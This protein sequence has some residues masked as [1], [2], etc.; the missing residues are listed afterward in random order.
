MRLQRRA[1]ALLARYAG[2]SSE[3]ELLEVATIA[4]PV[5]PLGADWLDR[6]R[7]QLG[8]SIDFTGTL[9]NSA[10]VLFEALTEDCMIESLWVSQPGAAL[11]ALIVAGVAL[12]MPSAPLATVATPSFRAAIVPTPLGSDG[13]IGKQRV[14]FG[15]FPP[16][17]AGGGLVIEDA[18]GISREFPVRGLIVQAGDSFMVQAFS[19]NT[20]LRVAVLYRV[21]ETSPEG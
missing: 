4:V 16:I 13:P 6:E 7:P 19:A 1:D 8:Y 20:R 12:L 9:G 10:S 21:L 15:N 2:P 18:V 17:G 3:G 14:S 5:I 11:G